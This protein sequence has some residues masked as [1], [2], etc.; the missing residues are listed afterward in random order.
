MSYDVRIKD[1][2]TGKTER[3]I[4]FSKEDFKNFVAEYKGKTIEVEF[5]KTKQ[6]SVSS[7]PVR[8]KH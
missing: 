8:I 1:M 6:D 4:V 2:G 7:F 5:F 3:R